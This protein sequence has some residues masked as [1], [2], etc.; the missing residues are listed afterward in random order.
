MSTRTS[1]SSQSV[2]LVCSAVGKLYVYF[3]PLAGLAFVRGNTGA[4]A[5]TDT[6]LAAS[7]VVTT[8]GWTTPVSLA[9]RTGGRGSARSCW[10]PSSVTVSS[11]RK[12]TG[13]SSDRSTAGTG[14]RLCFNYLFHICSFRF[15]SV[16]C[17]CFGCDSHTTILSLSHHSEVTLSYYTTGN[18]EMFLNNLHF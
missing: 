9:W 6:D 1:L 18:G 4:P 16:C 8:P 3:T 10:T 5:Y 2:Q 12:C 7:G 17:W 11:Y 14:A 13:S 15:S